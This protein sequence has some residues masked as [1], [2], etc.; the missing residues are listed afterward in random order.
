MPIEDVTGRSSMCYVIELGDCVLD[1]ISSWFY[2]VG[3]CEN[4]ARRVI[5]RACL[6]SVTDT[7]G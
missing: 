2:L 7:A 1:Q 5:V 3:G 4:A 6:S